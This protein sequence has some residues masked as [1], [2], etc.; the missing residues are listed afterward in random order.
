MQKYARKEQYRSFLLY[1]L[2]YDLW[3]NARFFLFRRKLSRVRD[4]FRG[5]ADGLNGRNR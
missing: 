4:L 2:G 5:M 3:E 1:F